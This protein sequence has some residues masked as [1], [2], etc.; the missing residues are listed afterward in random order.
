MKPSAGASPRVEMYRTGPIL[1]AGPTAHR[2]DGGRHRGFAG[3]SQA[4]L[5]RLMG[6]D[7]FRRPLPTGIR[8]GAGSAHHKQT[9]D[10]A[11]EAV[12][13]PRQRGAREGGKAV[14]ERGVAD[15]ALIRPAHALV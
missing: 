3:G 5:K 2:D 9:P 8:S 6:H 15:A 11:A 4:A 13:N 14:G 12:G 1:P 7:L 10:F